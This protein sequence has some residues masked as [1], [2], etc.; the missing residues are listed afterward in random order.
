LLGELFG[1]VATIADD[2]RYHVLIGSD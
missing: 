1:Q 2:R